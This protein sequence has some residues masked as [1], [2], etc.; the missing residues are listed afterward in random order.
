MC[1]N[2]KANGTFKTQCFSKPP[3]CRAADPVDTPKSC[4]SAQ[5]ADSPVVAEGFYLHL[6]F[7]YHFNDSTGVSCQWVHYG[8]ASVVEF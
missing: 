1:C 6:V 2:M 4:G 3:S 5:Q 7:I 8:Q